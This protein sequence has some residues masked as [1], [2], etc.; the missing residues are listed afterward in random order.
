MHKQL[1][2][3]ILYFSVVF[4]GS[5]EFAFHGMNFW[6]GTTY[7]SRLPKRGHI[8]ACAAAW[9]TLSPVIAE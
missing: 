3:A 2:S 4:K 5:L 8:T 7:H 6:L 9:D 1:V